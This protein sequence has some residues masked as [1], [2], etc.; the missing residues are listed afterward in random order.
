[1]NQKTIQTI[2]FI[3]FLFSYNLAKSEEP[4][5]K[6]VKVKEFNSY[7]E[8]ERWKG[9]EP[10]KEQPRIKV[11]GDTIKF[12]NEKGELIKEKRFKKYD[13]KIANKIREEQKNE[14]AE[15]EWGSVYIISSGERV[16]LKR[17]KDYGI[18]GSSLD[19]YEIYDKE[20]NLIKK[21]D[22]YVKLL[23]SPDNRYF[24]GYYADESGMYGE[25]KFFDINGNLL[26]TSNV[27]DFDGLSYNIVFSSDSK[28]VAVSR[29]GGKKGGISVFNDRGVLLWKK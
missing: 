12:Y 24:V 5:L 11:D 1:M 2:L 10:K 16:L 7:E 29:D 4:K 19:G 27:F 13:E 25:I 15:V 23:A 9:K 20:G 17:G 22:D 28:Y 14:S 6:I 21:I 8:Y 18:K 26:N 3:F